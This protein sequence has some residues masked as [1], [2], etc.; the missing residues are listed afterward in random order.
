MFSQ[1]YLSALT[2]TYNWY[3]IFPSIQICLFSQHSP[4]A[5]QKQR[6]Y[7]LRITCTLKIV[8]NLNSVNRQQKI[9]KLTLWQN[10]KE[11]M[12]KLRFFLSKSKTVRL[13]TI[14]IGFNRNSTKLE[15]NN[16]HHPPS[17][18][19]SPHLKLGVKVDFDKSRN[20]QIST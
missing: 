5:I 7:L 10:L 4:F 11:D 9:L 1:I 13:N 3:K 16:L 17:Q 2:Y 14:S 8:V 20:R 19:W 6:T 12:R 18:R 15:W